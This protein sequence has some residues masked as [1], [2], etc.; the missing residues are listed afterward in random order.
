MAHSDDDG[1]VYHQVSTKTSR[2]PSVIR[3]N[4]DKEVVMEY[5]QKLQQEISKLSFDNEKVK[6]IVERYA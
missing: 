2:Y 6:S 1:L 5:C 4:K 3:K